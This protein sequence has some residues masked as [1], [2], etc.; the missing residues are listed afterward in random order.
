MYSNYFLLHGEIRYM[1]L[2]I[3]RSIDLN[4]IPKM[5]LAYHVDISEY[6]IHVTFR[7]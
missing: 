5:N 3:F 4:R 7:I 2:Y 6:C 1:I